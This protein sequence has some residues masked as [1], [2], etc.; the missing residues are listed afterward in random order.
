MH[1]KVPLVGLIYYWKAELMIR[2][3]SGIGIYIQSQDLFF[4][5]KNKESSKLGDPYQ[6]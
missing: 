1:W 3:K 4:C 2:F 6:M 5:A